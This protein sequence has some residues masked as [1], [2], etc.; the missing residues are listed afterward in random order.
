M[1]YHTHTAIR[2]ATDTNNSCVVSL[3]SQF[4]NFN[5]NTYNINVGQTAHNMAGRKIFGGLRNNK[6]YGRSKGEII[7]KEE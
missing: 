2:R 6:E 5:S 7:R 3:K 1:K 4:G